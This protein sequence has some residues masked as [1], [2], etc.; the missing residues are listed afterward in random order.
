MLAIDKN[1][2][3]QEVEKRMSKTVDR[4]KK[5]IDKS[6][7]TTVVAINAHDIYTSAS[8]E[9]HLDWGVPYPWVDIEHPEAEPIIRKILNL[10]HEGKREDEETKQLQERVKLL[11]LQEEQKLLPL[12]DAFYRTRQMTYDSHLI[13]CRFAKGE[14]RLQSYG[15]EYQEFRSGEEKAKKLKEYQQ[16]MRD[17]ASF[18]RDQ[19]FES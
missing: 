4:L 18:L 16:E 11:H 12:L 2:V 6:I 19:F 5:R 9:G 8:C 13:L 10:L 1:Q 7:M 15:A 17:F 3:W 14:A